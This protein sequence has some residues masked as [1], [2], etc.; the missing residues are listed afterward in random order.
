MTLQVM[1]SRILTAGAIDKEKLE[2]AGDWENGGKDSGGSSFEERKGKK[3][4]K[5]EGKGEGQGGGQGGGRGGGR[6]RREKKKRTSVIPRT[7]C[8]MQV[9]GWPRDK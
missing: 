7:A 8:S 2:D 3:K 5:E 9:V 4:G 1:L 6:E